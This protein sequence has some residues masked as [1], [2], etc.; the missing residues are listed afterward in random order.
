MT[1][2]EK[3]GELSPEEYAMMHQRSFRTAFD[4][5]AAHFPPGMDPEWWDKSAKECSDASIQAGENTLVI[6]LLGAVMN[7]LGTEYERR[8]GYGKAEA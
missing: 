8:G 5:L 6:E 7:Y 3:K 1:E 2:S 4:F